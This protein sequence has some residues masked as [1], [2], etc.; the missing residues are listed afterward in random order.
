[1]SLGPFEVGMLLLIAA[2][3]FGPAIFVRAGGSIGK[4]IKEFKEAVREEESQADDEEADD[5]GKSF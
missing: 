2:V 3:A 5:E 4:G 1:M